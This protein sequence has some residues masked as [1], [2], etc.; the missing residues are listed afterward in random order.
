MGKI[1]TTS[2]TSAK[3]SSM[4][5]QKQRDIVM[6]EHRNNFSSPTGVPHKLQVGNKVWLHLQKERLTRAHQKLKPLRHG[7]YNITK[8]MG[9]NVWST[10]FLHSFACTEC[11]MWTVVDH[12]SHH[13]RTPQ[14]LQNSSP[15][16]QLSRSFLI[17]GR[18][19]MQWGPF[20]PKGGGMI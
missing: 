10:M 5:Q 6:K 17:S 20:L 12:A 4:Q 14:R 18:N 1:V 2:M 3:V 15:E 11:S 8:A 9:N 19:S 16:T 13:Y 7:P